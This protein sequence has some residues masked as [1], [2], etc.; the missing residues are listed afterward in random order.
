MSFDFHASWF[1]ILLLIVIFS[2]L[3]FLLY[4]ATAPP[5]TIKKRWLLAFLRILALVCIFL[6][7]ASTIFSF[8]FKQNLTPTIAILI[9]NSSSMN[10]SDQAGNRKKILESIL[11]SD[12]L[13]KFPSR[14]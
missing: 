2:L 4:K 1:S 3:I 7:V 6:V 10:F 5:L 8:T 11:K 12:F 13:K 9:D 14:V